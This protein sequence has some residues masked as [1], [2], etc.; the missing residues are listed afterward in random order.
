MGR[1]RVRTTA[2]AVVV[3]AA[4]VAATAAV[5]VHGGAP[6][7]ATAS[8]HRE[9]PLISQDPTADNTDLYAFVSPDK[10]STATIVSNWIP[11]EDPA[12]GPNYYTFSQTARYDIYAD[13]NGDGKPDI[14]WY[15][16]FKNL[17]SQFFL[18][19]T[20]QSYTVTKV[21][22]GKS[23]VVGHGLL[24]PPDNIGPRSTPNYDA[25]AA[26]GIHTLA[27]GSTVFAG[28]RDDPFFADVGAIFDLVAIR[29]GTGATG[30]GKDFLAGYAVHSIALQIPKSQLDNG[31][32]HVVGIWSATDRQQVSVRNGKAHGGWVQ[33]SRIGNPLINEVVIPTNLKDHWNA[34]SPAQDKQFE[35]S[36]S[37]PILAAVL[38]KLYPQFGPFKQT[39]RTDL[40]S[41]LGTGLASPKLNYTGPTFADEL[42][43]NLS[44][45]P[46]AAN[47]VSDLGVIGGDLAGY[48]NGRRLNDD[49]IDISERVVAGELVGHKLPLGDGVD[50]NDVSYLA[51]FPYVAPP[52][53]GFDDTHGQTAAK[54]G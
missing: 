49:V 47:K 34:T 1:P 48:P 21:E 51:S 20:Q 16:R 33:V 23:S 28:Q 25:L 9:A 37:S 29:E 46:T 11:G 50:A 14:A 15:F 13:R 17:P 27:D 19:N 39:G 43:L 24:T 7:A 32:N 40:V 42:R 10:P 31:S 26:K 44:I 45:P 6:Q 52:F 30:G 41:V 18:G 5:A 12:A 2:A 53:S 8:S 54:T 4:A 38:Q 36:Y 35:K 3:A 22:N